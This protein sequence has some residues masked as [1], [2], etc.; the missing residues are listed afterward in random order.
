MIRL[1]R[2][3]FSDEISENSGNEFWK[4]NFEGIEEWDYQFWVRLVG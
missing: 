4:K 2:G 1:T 3:D